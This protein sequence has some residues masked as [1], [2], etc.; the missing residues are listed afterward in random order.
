[1]II[2]A[3]TKRQEIMK[4][5]VPVDRFCLGFIWVPIKNKT[6]PTTQESNCFQKRAGARELIISR[7]KEKSTRIA[8][9]RRLGNNLMN[10]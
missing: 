7:L 9:I 3:K 6:I 4:K 1:M 2:G 10:F 5:K 8:K